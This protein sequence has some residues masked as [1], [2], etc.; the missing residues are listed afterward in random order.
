VTPQPI[1]IYGVGSPIAIDAEE[2][3]LR[4][5]RRIAAGVRN[6]EGPSYVSTKVTVVGVA[7]AGYEVKRCEIVLPMFTP[8]HRATARQDAEKRGFG[9]LATLVDPTS[10]VASSALIGAGV[11]INAGCTIGGAASLGE[12]VF[13]NRGAILGHHAVLDP[14]VSIGPGANIAGSVHIG[15]GAVI[16]AGAIV[17]PKIEIGANAVIGAGAVVTK[18]VPPNSMAV[19]NPAQIVRTNIAGFNDLGV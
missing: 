6:M 17:L 12:L 9:P 5:R 3:C 16:G 8:A 7:D 10:A 4:L 11:Y 18:P 1:V 19:G 14:L 13:V 15:R 2:T